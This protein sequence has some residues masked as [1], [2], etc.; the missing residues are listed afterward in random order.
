M[1]RHGEFFLAEA[2]GGLIKDHEVSAV[3]QEFWLPIGYPE[4]LER[5]EM[6]LSGNF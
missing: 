5:A 4:D 6:I 2:I 3:R 1:H